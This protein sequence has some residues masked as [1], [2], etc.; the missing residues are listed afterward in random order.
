MGGKVFSKNCRETIPR[1]TGRSAL[2]GR[3]GVRKV[4]GHDM[5]GV[6]GVV[7]AQGSTRRVRNVWT[8]F[9]RN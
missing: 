3:V 1:K 5:E 7:V 8:I 6:A 4:K 9:G 2:E